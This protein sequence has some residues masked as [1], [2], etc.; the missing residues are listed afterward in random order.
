MAAAWQQRFM[1]CIQRLG[2][3]ERSDPLGVWFSN[4]GVVAIVALHWPNRTTAASDKLLLR[5]AY[6]FPAGSVQS[7]LQ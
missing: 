5:T 4:L 7:F 2:R 1:V 3:E 6:I